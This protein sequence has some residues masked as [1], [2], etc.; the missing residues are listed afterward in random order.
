MPISLADA[1]LQDAT[2]TAQHK[3]T[4]RE[5]SDRMLENPLG[6]HHIYYTVS[7]KS[8]CCAASLSP[9]VMLLQKPGYQAPLE[10]MDLG[11]S[12]HVSC[13]NLCML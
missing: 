10:T 8:T 9:G 6:G 7:F 5:V 1:T 4:D 13:R 2:A 3:T 12:R 11:L